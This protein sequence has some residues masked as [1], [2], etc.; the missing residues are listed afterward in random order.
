MFEDASPDD[1]RLEIGVVNADGVVD[2]MRTLARTAVGQ[3]ER[4]PLVQATSATKIKVKLNR[5]VLYEVDGG[6]RKKIKS[7]KISVQPGAITVCLPKKESR[8]R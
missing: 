8:R 3:A 2:W 5:K 7:F 4:S 1:G 6:D